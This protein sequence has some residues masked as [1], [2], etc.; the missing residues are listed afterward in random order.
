M[1]QGVGTVVTDPVPALSPEC[2]AIDLYVTYRYFPAEYKAAPGKATLVWY[3]DGVQQPTRSYTLDG[4]SITPGFH[5]AES[6]WKRDMP[7]QHTVEILLLCGTDAIRTTFV[8]P[9]NNYSDAEYQSCLLYTSKAVS[10]SRSALAK[11]STVS[12][13]SMSA[14]VVALVF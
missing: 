10:S 11:S 14:M 8:V 6:V 2:R 4:S 7:T 12:N 3:V 13:R 9:V 5:I 1:L